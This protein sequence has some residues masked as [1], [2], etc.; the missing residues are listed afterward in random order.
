MGSFP[1]EARSV[2]VDRPEWI[3]SREPVVYPEAVAAMEKRVAEIV[4]GQKGEAVWFLEHPPLY[5]A[6]VS[7]TEEEIAEASRLPVYRTG[8]GGKMT[9][10]GPGQRVVYVMSDLRQRN[11][12]VRA[13]VWRL[14]EW[15]IRVLAKHDVKG[16]RRQ[17]RVGIWV[18]T[19]TGEEKIAA[20]GVR[21]RHGVTFHGLS[22]NV[23][24]D[25][26]AFGGIT[27]CGLKDYGVT[28]LSKLGAKTTM[29]GIDA[30]F[31]STWDEIFSSR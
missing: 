14:E 30:L 31:Q 10:H 26:S 19:E 21:V 22:L 8:R 16:E 20:I 2:I 4:D 15:I 28:S 18:Q 12:D 27:P 3:F 6:G 29:E 13:H 24:P 1:H 23:D 7:A 17:G 5:T 25:L 11:L 9:Y